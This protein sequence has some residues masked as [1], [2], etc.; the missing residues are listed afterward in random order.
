MKS[1]VIVGGSLAGG[2]AAE[3]LR[4]H[5]F[6]GRIVL[7]DSETHPPYERPPLS[8]GML[9]GSSDAPSTYLR[10]LPDWEAQSVELILGHRVVRIDTRQRSVELDDGRRLTTDNVLLCTGSRARR[11]NVPGE[12]LVGVTPLRTIGDSEFIAER[13]REG[14]KLVV[15]GAG[16]IGAEVASSARAMNSDVTMLESAALPLQRVLGARLGATFASEHRRRGVDLRTEST[17]TA[18]EGD[19]KVRRVL[20]SDGTRIE[21][22]L[23][24]VGVGVEPVTELARDAGLAVAN[25]IVIDEA[26]RTSHDSIYAAGDVANQLNPFFNARVRLETWQNAQDQG[27]S[28]AMSMLGEPAPHK[29]PWFWS[30]Q[31]DINFQMAGNISMD[32]T[33]VYRGDPDSL[34]FCEFRLRQGV[35]VGVIGLNQRRDVRAAMSLIEKRCVV[36]VDAL[37]DPSVDLRKVATAP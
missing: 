33:V 19:T 25:G 1:V 28:A 13:L 15:V 37:A 3:A 23:V 36:S 26:C 17:I 27:I 14:A 18:I 4:H 24:V 16:F 32:D 9:T 31:Y 12:D 30:D 5:G 8:K 22:D 35:L 6:D 21:A 10:S 29:V 2:R 11:L 34:T 7:V 20:L